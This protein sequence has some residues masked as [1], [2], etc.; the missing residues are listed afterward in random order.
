MNESE[1]CLMGGMGEVDDDFS[2]L[3]DVYAYSTTTNSF[4]QLVKNF[5]GLTQFQAEGNNA[6]FIAD[7]MVVA[8]G[9]NN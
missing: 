7:N 2:C 4:T 9:Q 8:L 1:I 3:G 5:H 6:A